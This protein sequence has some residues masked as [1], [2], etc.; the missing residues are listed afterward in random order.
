MDRNYLLSPI[1]VGLFGLI[2]FF[3]ILVFAPIS[4]KVELSINTI[5]Y[6]V[7]NYVMFFLG[8][9][10][11]Y[12]V[13]KKYKPRSKGYKHF[14]HNEITKQFNLS[15]VLSI[16]GIMLR[17]VDRFYYRNVS[18][19]QSAMDNRALLAESNGG[20]ISIFGALLYPVCFIVLYLFLKKEKSLLSASGGIVLILFFFPT[21]DSILFGSRSLILVNIVMFLLILRGTGNLKIKTQKIIY[22]IALTISLITVSGYM[23]L[24][25][26]DEMGLNVLD[27]IYL[28][29]YAKTVSPSD[30]V[31]NEL[32]HGLTVINTMLFSWLNFTQYYT[33]G[34]FEF[35]NFLLASVSEH[36]YGATQ[37]N[38]VYK[39]LE[40]ILPL[41][42]LDALLI[43]VNPRLGV[44]TTFFGPA[45]MDFGYFSP[46]ML[47][48]FG[49]GATWVYKKIS[50]NE[51]YYS[52][53]YY[54]M[55]I[56]IFFMPVVN[57]IQSAQGLY[58]IFS[59][60]FF[61]FMYKV[62]C[63]LPTVRFR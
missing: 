58:I 24:A 32:S 15:L 34:F 43:S 8:C 53:L 40:K 42:D 48:L 60:I 57:F 11:L 26:L 29:G 22:L 62:I 30:W 9:V 1:S 10:L 31:A 38:I 23:F 5:I 50:I 14:S 3:V 33:H 52:V 37:F 16:F 55:V 13:P 47:F 61:G 4:P 59:V 63:K 17:L 36:S 25:R 45:H 27:T 21:F 7:F 39:F 51:S 54:M 56:I 18:I 6:F 49:S 44:F 35:N 41:Q 46:Y 2:L 19:F 12:L 20:L 28:S